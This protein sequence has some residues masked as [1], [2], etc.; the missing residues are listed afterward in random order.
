[1]SVAGYDD[2]IRRPSS[3]PLMSESVQSGTTASGSFS[4]T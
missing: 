2:L 1:M 4:S 3:G